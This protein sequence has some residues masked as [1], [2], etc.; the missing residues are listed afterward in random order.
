MPNNI[1]EDSRL[2]PAHV[3]CRGFVAMSTTWFFKELG[4]KGQAHW[5][6]FKAF[7]ETSRAAKIASH[8]GL[9]QPMALD[10]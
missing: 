2:Q 1:D 10:E 9:S 3:G 6:A 7:S 4:G 5:Q 8:S